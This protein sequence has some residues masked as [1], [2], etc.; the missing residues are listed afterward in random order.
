MPETITTTMVT[1]AHSPRQ[2]ALSKE[3]E[4]EIIK[5]IESHCEKCS[6]MAF[7]YNIGIIGLG[8]TAIITSVLVSIYTGSDNLMS[9][10]TL[11]VLACIST[12]SLMLLTAFNLVNQSNDTRNAWRALNSSL[13]LYKAGGMDLVK[14]IEQYQRGEKQPGLA[15]FSYGNAQGTDQNTETVTTKTVR[16]VTNEAGTTETSQTEQKKGRL[17]NPALQTEL[18]LRE[19]IPTNGHL[20]LEE[21]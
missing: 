20:H 16:T 9:A 8:V 12:I 5:K 7:L 4:M 14:L 15:S 3:E 2:F 11:K 1:T 10:S 21:G 13:M 19:G 18:G 17:R 6:R